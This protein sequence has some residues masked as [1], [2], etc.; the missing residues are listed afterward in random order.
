R[1]LP[2]GLALRM[3][4][5]PWLTWAA[6]AAMATVL[7]LM[8]FDDSARPQLLWSAGA[9][10]VVLVVALVRGFRSDDTSGTHSHHRD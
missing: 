10:G 2:S 8:V 4:G 6:L 7:V 3:W 9:T 1:E 5:F